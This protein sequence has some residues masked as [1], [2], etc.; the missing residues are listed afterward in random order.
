MSPGK[1]PS[2]VTR[3]CNPS[4]PTFIHPFSHFN[5]YATHSFLFF[6]LTTHQLREIQHNIQFNHNQFLRN[7]W[8]NEDRLMIHLHAF[9]HTTTTNRG[10]TCQA[11]NGSAHNGS[12]RDVPWR[13][14]PWR[15]VPWRPRTPP[16]Q[17]SGHMS[18]TSGHMSQTSGHHR[19]PSHPTFLHPFSHFNTHA[20]SF[21]PFFHSYNTST[22]RNSTQYSIQP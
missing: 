3:Q 21:I 6:I 19:I 16:S 1:I 20:N 9:S 12:A 7:S 18:Q 5:S 8:F 14:V 17:I 4:H 10:T 2:R 11:H 13:D 15:D 22:E